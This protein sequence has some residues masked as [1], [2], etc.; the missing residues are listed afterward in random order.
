MSSSKPTLG[1]NDL[2]SQFPDIAAEA[3]G[4]DPTTVTKGSDQKKEWKCNKGHLYSS[5]VSGRTIRGN[6]CPICAGNQVLAGFNDLKTKFPDIAAEAYGWD[7]SMVMPGT[8]QKKDWKCKEGHLYSS[9]VSSRTSKGTGC[10][11]CDGKQVLAGFNDLKTKF[12]DIAKEAYGW[13]T[14]MVMPG[15]NQKKDWKC[16]EGHLYSS[17][18][19]SRTSKGTGCPFCAG[20]QVL[21]GFNDLKTKFPDIAKEAYGWDTSMVMPG[22]NQ[23]KD[24]KC[25]EG[26][27]YHSTVNRRTG[28]GTG[29][30]FC[31]GKKIS[32]GF[33]D[34]K[35]KFPDI[36][37]EAYGWDPSTVVAGTNQK[38][39]WKCKEGHLYSSLV[40]SRTSEGTGCAV[41]AGNQVLAGFNDLKT[42]FP[43]I[44]AEAYG[45]DPSTVVAG[46][47]QKKDWKCKEGHLYHSTV[48][49]RTGVGTGCP[50][51]AG[52]KISAGF[53]DLQSQFPDIA[54]EAYGWDPTTVTSGANQ[55]KEWKCKEGHLY[56][57]DVAGRTIRGNGCPYCSGYKVLA[58]FN[59]LKTKF[60]D[61]ASEAYG[62]D[63][64]TVVAG[65][66]QKKDWKCK[67]GHL[68]HSTV[69]SRTSGGSGCAVCAEG[70][71]NPDKDAW[72][73]LM[74]RP[75]E[76]QLGI[77]NVI[78]DRLRTHE[79][80][81]WS[82][83][84]H[85]SIPSKGQKVLDTEKAFK[86]W[87]RKEIGIMEG[88]TENWSTTKMEVQSL[89]ELKARSGI[90]TDLF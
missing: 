75:G 80:N 77:S 69:N 50:F 31:A 76:Q 1:V 90:E 67:E 27:L 21:E 88:T 68:Y 20:Q 11:V 47:N 59:D 54:K 70:G 8:K 35:T 28:V 51:C 30:P 60:P 12:P 71:F 4:W 15:T 16:K 63:P 32:A 64:S 45:W 19:S 52:K 49:S 3:Y 73:Y 13:D 38:K 86:K 41:C 74:E 10:A 46:T 29:C 44:A 6:G 18:V 23:K 40:S 72:F 34:L 24:W 48:N 42:K 39:D 79:S 58:G 89:A 84:E 85:T 26:H 83:I 36:A 9:L 81:G 62:W 25:K 2:Q 56:N 14:S 5:L 55:K 33:N 61:I 66:N 65:T 37:A 82:L 57:S 17:L 7:T 53:N 22:T 78:T 87:L 43:D